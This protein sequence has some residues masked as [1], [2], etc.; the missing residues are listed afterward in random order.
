M[1]LFCLG[2]WLEQSDSNIV[3]A[4]QRIVFHDMDDSESFSVFLIQTERSGRC[5]ELVK[6]TYGTS[7]QPSSLFIGQ[8]EMKGISYP[9]HGI[10]GYIRFIHIQ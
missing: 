5:T 3:Y 9:H 2:G 10:G 4:L 8:I 1:E 7:F 6:T